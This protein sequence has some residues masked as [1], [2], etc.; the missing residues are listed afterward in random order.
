MLPKRLCLILS[1][2]LPTLAFSQVP[3]LFDLNKLIR[4]ETIDFA[5]TPAPDS[6]R[7]FP[8]DASRVESILGRNCRVLPNDSGTMKYFAYNI[9][10]GKGLKP[11]GA[12]VLV[13][14]YPEDSPRTMFVLNRGN[15]TGRGLATGSAVA[16]ALFGK[17]V[18]N[19]PESISYSLSGAWQHWQ[20]FF[21]LHD[22]FPA[23]ESLRGD[24][25]RTAK[26]EEGFWVIIAQTNQTDAT[27]S[28][29]AAVAS[30]SLYEVPHPEQYN[31][32][33]NYPPDGLPKRYL[34][35]RE[36][37]ADGVVSV[38]HGPDNPLVRGVDHLSLIHI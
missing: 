16:D 22:R 11:G 30:I 23:F 18:N 31:L 27:G 13:V 28:S 32:K 34:F 7:Q 24:K 21:Y 5:L 8:E 36:E 2:A 35:C 12:Y 37:M 17:Y 25:P 19:N 3:S 29:G 15:E 33:I 38:P 14:E 1:L 9:G 6:F 10:R 20:Q 4:V 26:P